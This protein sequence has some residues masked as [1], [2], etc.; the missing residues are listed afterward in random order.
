M[1]KILPGQVGSSE[2]VLVLQPVVSGQAEIS[3]AH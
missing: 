2:G 1:T 3:V